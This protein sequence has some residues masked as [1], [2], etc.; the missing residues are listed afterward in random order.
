MENNLLIQHSYHDEI[1]FSDPAFGLLKGDD[2]WKMLVEKSGGNIHLEF[3]MFRQM[4]KKV[5]MIGWLI[6]FFVTRI[7]S[8]SGNNR[9]RHS[10]RRDYYSAGHRFC[11]PK[12][13]KKRE[14]LCV[15]ILNLLNSQVHL[16]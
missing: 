7:I 13:D 4:L 15:N 10:E 14:N 6:I 9:V 16:G 8:I 1:E 11:K 2:E 12:S 5:Q 3:K